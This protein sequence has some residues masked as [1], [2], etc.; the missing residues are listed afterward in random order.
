M[1]ESVYRAG[2]YARVS[3]EDGD[4]A[5]SES[6]KG[7]LALLE[8]FC[9]EQKTIIPAKRYQ[10]DGYSGTNF[11]R[12]AFQELL[13]DIKDGSINC[14][15]VKDLSRFGRDY[16]GVG[17]YLE[18]IL[19]A[20]GVRFISI[21]DNIDSARE[22]YTMLMPLSNV[23]N[24]QYA[25]DIAGKTRT[26][27][28][29]K[30][31]HGL[32]TGAFAPYGY[33]KAP[34]N[35]NRLVPD[36]VTAPVV[37]RIFSM[38]ASDTGKT[39]IAS[40]LNADGVASPGKRR[41][42]NGKCK[43]DAGGMYW[44]SLAISRIL[45]N[46]VYI[47]NMCQGKSSVQG[48]KGK[49]QMRERQDWMIVEN[50]HPAIIE[51]QL[52]EQVQA[53]LKTHTAARAGFMKA[54]EGDNPFTGM[55]FCGNCGNRHKLIHAKGKRAYA[56]SLYK[57]AGPSTCSA[58]YVYEQMLAGYVLDDVNGMLSGVDDLQGLY[59]EA[60]KASEPTHTEKEINQISIQLANETQRKQAAYESYREGQLT[61]EEFVAR[62]RGFDSRIQTWKSLLAE[63]TAADAAAKAP[64]KSDWC[65][66]LLRDG[67]LQ[68]V[69][70]STVLAAVDRIIVQENK[71]IEI[72]YRF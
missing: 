8:S 32:F 38:Y 28:H 36:A 14:V 9:R 48:V 54:G 71:H 58:H 59:D 35:H 26:A 47:G 18:R 50:T 31:I 61:R 66:A 22:A 53:K 51:S 21:N 10:D 23:L 29:T 16:I 43:E 34:E 72:W 4:D 67:K 6:I 5:D 15:V 42:E 1:E 11:Q 20:F 62:K 68:H 2:L 25:K 52:W 19:P 7:Q 44:N 57:T 60:V 39:R 30:H 65:E 63:M 12:P 46:P 70:R 64:K 49:K 17:E 24:A 45:S 40:I 56:C 55:I 13:S 33:S 27:I 37:Q 69:D 3:R 41:A